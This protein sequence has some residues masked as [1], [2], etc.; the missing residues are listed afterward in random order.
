[1][2]ICVNANV[3]G[4]RGYFLMTILTAGL[5]YGQGGTPTFGTTVVIPSGLKGEVFPLAKGTFMLP[6]FADAEPIG[7][8]WT[9]TLNIPPRRWKA[10]FPGVTK[11]SEWFAIDYTGRFWIERPGQYRFALLSDDGSK[12]YIDDGLVIDN[13]C[14]HPPMAR[15]AAIELSGGIH[16]IRVSYFQGPRDCIALQLLI[17]ELAEDWRL[18]STDEFKPPENTDAWRYGGKDQLDTSSNAGAGRP[19]LRDALKRKGFKERDAGTMKNPP[20]SSGCVVPDPVPQC[21]G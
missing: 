7:T 21:H 2:V 8:I 11:R 15:K 10:G 16:H 5:S 6:D 18:F 1:V 3:P 4:F 19:K 14:Q 20:S 12:L 9:S 17:A 13:D